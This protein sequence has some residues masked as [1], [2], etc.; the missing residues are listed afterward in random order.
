M[1]G[2]AARCA[3]SMSRSPKQSVPSTVTPRSNALAVSHWVEHESGWSIK[4]FVRTT[5]RYR[6]VK[7]GTQIPTAADPLPDDLGD[8]LLKIRASRMH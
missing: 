3:A 4:K 7:A 2:R 1:T 6:T 5:R 8:A